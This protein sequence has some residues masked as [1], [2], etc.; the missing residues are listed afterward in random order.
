MH[1]TQPLLKTITLVSMLSAA[2]IARGAD[3]PLKVEVQHALATLDSAG[4]HVTYRLKFDLRLFNKSA[5]PVSLPSIETSEDSII[6][7]LGMQSKSPQ[8]LWTNLFQTSFYGSG[9]EKYQPCVALPPAGTKE[10][11][12]VTKR[13]SL[14][15]KQLPDLGNEP[16]LRL[17]LMLSCRRPDG[18]VIS[19][20]FLTE[21]F[22]L[23]LPPP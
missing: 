23:R 7:L 22:T 2:S 15:S 8:G 4:G 11:V 21:G 13:F 12:G 19:P 10:V 1:S 3:E 18:S 6:S 14:L 5:A 9:D 20:S 17:Y 16:T